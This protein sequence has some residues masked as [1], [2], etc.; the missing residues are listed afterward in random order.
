M[1]SSPISDE[2]FDVSH[3]SSNHSLLASP[4][5]NGDSSPN[6]SFIKPVSLAAKFD[7]YSTDDSDLE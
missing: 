6:R 7:Y 5:E 4:L 3:V 1:E 2:D